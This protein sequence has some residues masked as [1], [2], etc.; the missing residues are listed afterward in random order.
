MTLPIAD[1]SFVEATWI[2][3]VKSIVIFAV[4]FAIVPMPPCTSESRL[5]SP[6]M[7]PAIGA[8]SH[9]YQRAPAADA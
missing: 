2:L 6:G 3:V 8:M 5:G 9:A 4:I 7:G 1:T